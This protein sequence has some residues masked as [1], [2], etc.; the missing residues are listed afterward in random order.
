MGSHE[1]AKPGGQIL[2]YGSF[3]H[4]QATT[5]KRREIPYHKKFFLT[6]FFPPRADFFRRPATLTC[7]VLD[8]WTGE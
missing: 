4:R 3:T 5:C 7:H 8:F 2:D 1:E 6:I